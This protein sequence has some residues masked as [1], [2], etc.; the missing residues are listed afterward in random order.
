MIIYDDDGIGCSVIPSAKIAKAI[1]AVI[2]D[3]WDYES[4]MVVNGVHYITIVDA[5]ALI[6]K[7]IDINDGAK[8]E[9]EE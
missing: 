8:M 6:E 4:T 5:V 1:E 2:N 9:V 3:F 7:H